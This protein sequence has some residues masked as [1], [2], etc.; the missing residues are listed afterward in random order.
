MNR[1]LK[2]GQGVL[3]YALLL[4]AII[5]V[6]VTAFLTSGTGFKDKIKTAYDG[7]GTT[8]GNVVNSITSGLCN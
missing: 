2:S 1:K 4:G 5:A 8:I 3:E 6:M 7:T